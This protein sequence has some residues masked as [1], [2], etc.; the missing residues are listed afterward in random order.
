MDAFMLYGPV[1]PD[2][3]G[4]CYNPHENYVLFA[5]TSFKHC[6]LTSSDFFACTLE[7]SFNEMQ[8]LCLSQEKKH[9]VLDTE[10][11][12][13]HV[14]NNNHCINGSQDNIKLENPGIHVVANGY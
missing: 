5:V 7:T 2:G 4:V 3:Y 12:N 8:E 6:D 14:N 13:S 10:K 1:V 9:P 11:P